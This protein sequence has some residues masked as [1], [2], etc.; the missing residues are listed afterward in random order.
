MFRFQVVILEIKSKDTFANKQVLK[1]DMK[2]KFSG[3][4][5]ISSRHD[6]SKCSYGFGVSKMAV[7]WEDCSQTE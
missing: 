1:L 7:I 2:L 3:A 5:L 6:G 4:C